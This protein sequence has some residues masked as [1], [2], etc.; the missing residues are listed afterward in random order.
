MGRQGIL[1]RDAKRFLEICNF[2]D[3]EN[4]GLGFD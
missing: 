2:E 4:V 1:S 3:E